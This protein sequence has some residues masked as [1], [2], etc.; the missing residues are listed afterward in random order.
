M[1]EALDLLTKGRT[2]LVIAHRLSTIRHV[3]KFSGGLRAAMLC[4]P[5]TS[6]VSDEIAVLSHG[7]VVERGT[8][9]QLLKQGGVYA[10]LVA[11]QM[12]NSVDE[13]LAAGEK[14]Q[15]RK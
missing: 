2:V 10:D 5:L 1:Q 9:D 3:G 4:Q 13:Q 11:R 15:Q 8:H 7:K 14:Q 12:N 6:G